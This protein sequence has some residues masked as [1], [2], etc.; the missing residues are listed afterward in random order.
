MRVLS[1]GEVLWDVYASS[2]HL[3][4]ASFN[5][6]AHF[7]KCGGEAWI[8]TA[9]GDDDFGK[10]TVNNVKK[11]GI[12]TSYITISEKE[13]GKCF[14]TLNDKQIPSY[15]LLNNVAY[16]DIKKPAITKGFFDALYFGTLALRCENNR[17]VIKQIISENIFDMIFVDLNI[18][19][20]YYSV[21]V[22]RFACA[23]ATILKIS[24]EELPVVMDILNKEESSLNNCAEILK[25]EFN[26]LK[27]IIITKG[28]EGSLVYECQNR[29]FFPCRAQKVKV[30]ST[31]G[32]GDSFSA[33]FLAKYLE[34]NDISKA[35][36]F[37]AKISAYV[38][39]CID[40][41]PEYDVNTLNSV[42]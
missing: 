20:P 3:G 8:N 39:S 4:G 35:L 22:V 12:N 9:V 2:K 36:S 16:D 6:A 21:D 7:K 27:I 24:D 29:R 30:V 40:A 32:A 28:E 17:N 33:A 23:N 26:N 11:A 15:N 5:F 41:V 10:E 1:F 37:A 31:V 19:P 14:V 34:T 13:T 42:L 38:V 18:R 25:E